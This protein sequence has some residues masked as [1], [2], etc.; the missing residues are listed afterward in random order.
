MHQIA[1]VY[2]LQWAYSRF[3]VDKAL[4]SPHCVQK[5]SGTLHTCASGTNK[6]YPSF[7]LCA[8]RLFLRLSCVGQVQSM[9]SILFF[10]IVV[11]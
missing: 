10:L 11:S 1:P 5:E 8:V 9:P 2:T 6:A 4:P 3:W 7:S